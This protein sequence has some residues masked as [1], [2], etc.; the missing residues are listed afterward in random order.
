MIVSFSGVDCAGKGTHISA[1]VSLLQKH[2]KKVVVIWARGGYTPLFEGLKKLLRFL[3][4]GR[5]PHSGDTSLRQ[6]HFKNIFISKIWL[7]LAIFDLIVVWCLVPRLL[8]LL[9]IVVVLDRF[10]DDTKIDFSMNFPE[11]EWQNLIVWRALCKL[12]PKPSV[13]FMLMLGAE[14]SVARAKYK[15][16]PFPESVERVF[17]RVSLYSEQDK[18]VLDDYVFLDASQDVSIVFEKVR[19]L[20]TQKCEFLRD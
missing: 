10:I 8:Q 17:Q 6:K 15:Q 13:K 5:L 9:G 1:L 7:V 20:I 19:I 2:E 14:A 18:Y 4:R 12:L 16:E 11:V 3:A